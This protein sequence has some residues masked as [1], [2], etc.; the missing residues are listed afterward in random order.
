MLFTSG[1]ELSFQYQNNMLACI[2]DKSG[3]K[4]C[5]TYH[6][7][8]L[9]NM[10]LSNQGKVSY[11][12]T[13]E[14]YLTHI[15][16]ENG[17]CY[18]VNQYDRKGRVT[19]QQ[20][21]DGEEYIFMYNPAEKRNSVT[22]M[23]D[24]TTTTYFYNR[25][26]LVERTVYD[27]GT[28]TISHYDD[29]ECVIYEKNKIGFEIYREYTNDGKL[30]RETN[31]SGY[32]MQYS[33]DEAGN[34]IC[35]EDNTGSRAEFGYDFNG[36]LLKARILL[37]EGVW[38]EN[39]FAYDTHGR[40]L[41]LT[42][43]N[44][45]S[46][47]WKYDTGYSHASVYLGAEG[48]EI[49][50]MIDEYGRVM[51]EHSDRGMIEYSY[52]MLNYITS[53]TDEEG[54]ST[55]KVY[56][57]TGKVMKLVRPNQSGETSYQY[58]A[59][60]HLI[61]V[62]DPC[63]NIKA[64]Q[65]DSEGRVTKEI[66]PNSYDEI[67]KDGEGICH[68]Y[69][70][71]GNRIKTIYA[72]GSVERRFYDACGNLLKFIRPEEYDV[73]GDGGRGESF[74]Y[75]ESGRLQEKR[76]AE[77]NV[78]KRYVYDT[79]GR[80]VKEING[81]G[82]NSAG[83]DD[84]RIGALFEY[85]LAGWLISERIPIAYGESGGM[86][87]RLTTYKY[88]ACGNVTEEKRYLD[89]QTIDSAR[90][91]VL[92]ITKEYDKSGRL[93][94]VKDSTGACVQYAY[95]THNQRIREKI[96]INENTWLLKKYDYYKNGRLR[97]LSESTDS[98]KKGRLFR[99]TGFTYDQNG[100]LTCIKTPSG[101]KI[102]REYDAADR[103][104]CEI[105]ESMNK[106]ISQHITF[107][108]DK[109][110]NLIERKN[111]TGILEQRT[112]N[113]NNMTTTITNA[114]G[115][116]TAFVYNRNGEVVKK[117]APKAYA[118]ENMQGETYA[119]DTSGRVTEI[120]RAD[121]KIARTMCYNPYGELEAVRDA[122]GNGIN[123]TYDFMGR[124]KQIL[125]T[126]QASQQYQYDVMGHITA[127]TDGMGV[128]TEYELDSWGRI[129]YIHKADQSVEH[130]EYDYAGNVT[131]A[132]DGEN[133]CTYFAYNA[134]NKLMTRTDSAG[135]QERWE[136]DEEG[137]VSAYTDRNGVT[138]HYSYNMY[139]SMTRRYEEQSGLQENWSYQ[140]DG[141]LLTADGGGRHYYYEYDRMGNLLRKSCG[142]R[143]LLAY[144]Y[145]LNG[146]RATMTD[147]TGKTVNYRYDDND[148]LTEV[149]DGGR[150]LAKYG[151]YDDLTR[152]SILTGEDLY[153]EYAYDA[154]KN[155][156][157][158]QTTLGDE[159]LQ[160][161][162]YTYDGNGNML[163]KQTMFGLTTYCYD[164]MGML[165]GVSSPE[166][167]EHYAYDHAGNRISRII[168]EL[169]T[170][171]SYDGCNRLQSITQQHEDHTQSVREC[172]Y[173][174]NGNML[175]DSDNEY[176]YDVLNRNIKTITSDGNT[177]INRYDAEQLRYE[178]EENGRLTSFIYGEDRQAETEENE[179]EGI[180]RHI[181]GYDLISCD[182]TA[183]RCYYH[184]VSD[185]HGSVVYL[186]KD[187]ETD[188]QGE[189]DRI[190]NRYGYDAFGNLTLCEEKVQNRFRYCGEQ[191]DSITGQHYLR[192]RYYN[193]VIGRFLQEDTY[194]KDSLNLY[195]YCK[196][197]PVYYADPS[198]HEVTPA[199]QRLTGD[200][201]ALFDIAG[202]LNGK[203][204][205]SVDD[206]ATMMQWAAEYGV[207]YEK[208]QLQNQLLLE[209]SSVDFFV[210]PNGEVVTGS[211]Y[212]K[213]EKVF[214][215]EK[216]FDQSTGNTIWPGM[217]GDPN[218]DGFI[219]GERSA[220][221]LKAGV[222]YE[223][224]GDNGN[225]HYYTCVGESLESRALPP[226]SEYKNTIKIIPT[227]DIPCT[228]GKI[229]PW[230]DQPGEGTQYFTTETRDSLEQQGKIIV[231]H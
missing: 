130:Y 148:M 139:G 172:C 227:E 190:L 112:Y 186:I 209:G 97:L 166:Y 106:D 26:Q 126:G 167:E 171:Y 22:R 119:Y 163:S 205:A 77:G 169:E 230:F 199:T 49:Q 187:R 201:Q 6:G 102:Y 53:I 189:N 195:A 96:R 41:K 181:R 78:V 135:R 206:A 60:D 116:T 15:T 43:A 117:I 92:I 200:Q 173:D 196:N 180:K 5:F 54:F 127:V 202:E 197:N 152:K 11:Q 100:N 211:D 86:Q 122:C 162:H 118:A 128:R 120:T 193:P 140:S 178:M 142:N 89:P 7:E 194:Y 90:G 105:H 110:G 182:S 144:T 101:N 62:T 66:H 146:N 177:Q 82:Y 215:N 141:R 157:S 220:D 75:D 81:K 8:L 2:Q 216:Y 129:S 184:Y 27:D 170:R 183:A 98:S 159:M 165:I 57:A 50:Y 87:Y 36:N 91:K 153:T 80:I 158:M 103:L 223:R 88:D 48:E 213:Y 188:E 203:G 217:N 143:M 51:S 68:E 204:G 212:L 9:E 93:V 37:D 56:D 115:G 208:L 67:S 150:V 136:Y 229:A 3:R 155:L 74:S 40:L 222:E 39:S 44:G 198:G 24:N 231:V 19:R 210:R 38:A 47:E 185:E 219:N 160:Q 228:S 109:A 132:I 58:D 218:I 4:C 34:L 84:A 168:G 191:Y 94:H 123:V 225:A 224:Y 31:T 151:Y 176:T 114:N 35:K 149:I 69:D 71:H 156:L 154:D 111:D 64:V 85:N 221:V 59:M 226:G 13:T 55:Q 20:T 52:N 134:M 79:A 137:N 95:N 32:T 76:D 147:L 16:N 138:I 113:L 17:K 65:V 107:C 70:I 33:Y 124:R 25:K 125:T 192:A 104:V 207:P 174:S 145:D 12:Y 18:V 1:Q 14:G 121:G 164:V 214:T 30:I 63:G 29:N 161:N 108:Y 72:D 179:T 28:E 175:S 133:R 42:D 46:R 99:E 23:S 45:N 61:K 73:S 21:A 10:T 83:N 131:T